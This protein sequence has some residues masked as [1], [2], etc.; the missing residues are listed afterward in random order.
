[1]KRTASGPT[2]EEIRSWWQER[3][4]GTD[5]YWEAVGATTLQQD[6]EAEEALRYR[7]QPDIFAFAQF[8]RYAGRRVLEVGVGPGVDFLQWARAGAVASGIDITEAAIAATKERLRAHGLSADLRV[9]D[10]E[11]LPFADETFDLVYSWGVLHH[12]P[13]TLKALDETI[14]VVKRGG[15]VKLML[16]NRR[17][18]LAFLFWVKRGLLRGH[19]FWGISQALA[20]CMESPGT[21]AYTR[22]EIRHIL[23]SRAVKLIRIDASASTRDFGPSSS[24][25][26]VGLIKQAARYALTVLIGLNEADFFMKIEFERL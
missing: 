12:T 10:A 7:T 26:P 19:P 5:A 14:R 4:C 17:S 18:L 20:R 16:Y 25:G 15:R 11:E 23:S 2:K 24:P 1:M 13:D 8:T 3:V 6:I 22:D 9:A 21:K